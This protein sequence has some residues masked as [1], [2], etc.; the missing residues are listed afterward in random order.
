MNK[1]RIPKRVAGVKVPK[2]V[3]KKAKKA[4]R[5]AESP[6]VREFAAAAIGAAAQSGTSR[7]R[8]RDPAERRHGS[9]RIDGD[10]VVETIRAAAL[11]GIQRFLQGF[12]EG[13]RNAARDDDDEPRRRA[14]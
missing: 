9:L 12:E 10:K 13:L 3:R 14:G 8:R 7:M 6:V 5:A 2:K 11:E 1:I 4:L